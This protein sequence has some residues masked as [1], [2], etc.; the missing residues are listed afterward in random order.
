[1]TLPSPLSLATSRPRF[2]FYRFPPPPA[3]RLHGLLIREEVRS[4]QC[5]KQ[6]FRSLPP[7]YNGSVWAGGSCLTTPQSTGFLQHGSSVVLRYFVEGNSFLVACYIYRG[8]TQYQFIDRTILAVINTLSV[9]LNL[10][11]HMISSAIV[12]Y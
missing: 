8:M 12:Q 11:N 9:R 4:H 3:T 2:H 5:S 10:L 7:R 6:P 1:M